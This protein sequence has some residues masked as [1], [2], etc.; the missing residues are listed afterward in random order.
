MNNSLPYFLEQS[1]INRSLSL[2]YLM[3]YISL[4]LPH[5][6]MVYLGSSSLQ[7]IY[8]EGYMAW[9]LRQERFL[10]SSRALGALSAQL[11]GIGKGVLG[12]SRISHAK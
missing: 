2:T 6:T 12:N 8:T 5:L 4:I 7:E 3:K 1:I 11:M 9:N 10:R